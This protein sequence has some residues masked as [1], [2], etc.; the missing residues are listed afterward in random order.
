MTGLTPA[1]SLLLTSP[2]N[3]GQGAT[4]F[5][6]DLSGF[7]GP[8]DLLRSLIRDEQLDIYDIPVARI[9]DQFLAKMHELQ[10]NEAAE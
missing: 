10:L 1:A 3:D 2:A 4:P 6:V 7:N 9:C 8:R 5:L